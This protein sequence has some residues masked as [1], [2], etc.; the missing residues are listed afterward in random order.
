MKSKSLIFAFCFGLLA[1]LWPCRAHDNFTIHPKISEGAGLS[2][3]GLPNFLCES[4]GYGID[5]PTLPTFG[6]GQATNN[7]QSPIGWIKSGSICEDM[8]AM[9][10]KNHFYDPIHYDHNH[11]HIGLTD[12]LDGFGQSSFKWATESYR[13]AELEKSYSWLDARSFELNALTN[14]S[15]HVRD[16]ELAKTLFYLGHVLHLNQD[17]SVPAHVRNDNHMLVGLFGY[18]SVH[19][20]MWT[21]KYGSLHC[22]TNLQWFMNQSHHD[23]SWWQNTA[24]F[25]KLEDFWNRDLLSSNGAVALTADAGNYPG[26]ELGLSEFCNGNFISENAPY[27]ELIKSG[28]HYF[29]YPSLETST[30]FSQI[31]ANPAGYVQQSRLANGTYSNR[32][33]IGKTTKDGITVTNHSVLTY[34][35][36]NFPTKN[37]KRKVTIHDDNVLQEYHSI[38]LPKAVEYS[39]GILDYFFRGTISVSVSGD[40]SGNYTITVQNTSGQDFCGGSLYLFQDDE[41]GNRT[42]VTNTAVSGIA[43]GGKM[44]MPFSEAISQ[45]TNF[46]LVYKGTIGTKGGNPSDPVDAGIA[47]AAKCFTLNTNS[48]TDCG[49]DLNPPNPACRQFTRGPTTGTG[50]AVTAS[51]PNCNFSLKGG[52]AIKT[53]NVANPTDCDMS[54]YILCSFYYSVTYVGDKIYVNGVLRGSSWIS[55]PGDVTYGEYGF[56][57]LYSLPA[58]SVTPFT[59]E[60]SAPDAQFNGN[61]WLQ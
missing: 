24:K 7:P 20:H 19:N 34:L 13:D 12:G 10:G 58:H 39:A 5:G 9:R 57:H 41:S 27:G 55:S 8:P 49:C 22:A 17:L 35:G 46:I 4:Y 1:W 11:Q 45:N 21:E 60:F 56:G 16:T 18:G 48:C 31:R 52:D 59:F 26:K 37:L 2:S 54:L 61:I 3:S 6:D 25:Q 33:V 43:N 36:A 29:Q 32:V 42:F 44:A 51:G 50:G 40:G 38:L 53:V 28:K 47:I 14:S 30:D 15:K 23:W